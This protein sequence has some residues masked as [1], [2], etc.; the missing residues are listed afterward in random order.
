MLGEQNISFKLKSP[1][2]NKVSSFLNGSMFLTVSQ[3]LRSLDAKLLVCLLSK[4]TEWAMRKKV[5]VDKARYRR[6]VGKLIYLAHTRP[7]LAYIVSMVS[8]FIYDPRMRHMQTVDH[9]LQYLKASP[10]RGLLFKRDG[11]MST[12]S[13]TYAGYVG[14]INDRRST[15][16]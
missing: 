5:T 3:S 11:N 9:I 4:I 13:Y 15:L 2:P 12:E 16:G 8:Q 7:T 6:L 10:G 1:T 14:S